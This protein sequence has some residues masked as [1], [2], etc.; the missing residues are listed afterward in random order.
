[1]PDHSH[2][3]AHGNQSSSD[4]D[5][6]V[7]VEED[8][9]EPVNVE[10]EES[11]SP[12]NENQAGTADDDDDAGLAEE[13]LN[14]TL[15]VGNVSAKAKAQD[16]KRMFKKYGPIETVRIR[17]A[18][19]NNS[20]LPKKVAYLAQRMSRFV[21]SVSAYVVF[22]PAEDVD[23]RLA[24]A[25]AEL[26]FAELK[27]K[28][29][30]VTPAIQTKTGPK[31][32]SAFIGNVPFDCTEEEFITT[33][34]PVAEKIG[35]K[36]LNVRLNRDQDTGIGRGIGFVTLSDDV[37]VQALINMSGEISIR[38]NKLRITWADKSQNRLSHTYKRNQ[39]RPR[40]QNYRGRV[41]KPQWKSQSRSS[42]HSK[43]EM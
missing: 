1:M 23:D 34:L 42:Y 22:K 36:L 41:R 12:K 31:K 20:K 35:T 14:R 21:D 32:R 7:S 26:H 28:H 9:S 24:K 33:F 15:F 18:V 10:G 3:E 4:Q 38:N 39:K 19:S 5:G 27:G 6:D 25:C 29:I 11:E 30:R 17:N 43:H 13:R 2:H 8:A 16:V 40:P 37:A